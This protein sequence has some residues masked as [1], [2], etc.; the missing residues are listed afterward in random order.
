[1]GAPYEEDGAAGAGAPY[2]DEGAAGAGAPYEEDPPPPP[3]FLP[4]KKKGE[5]LA[6]AINIARGMVTKV[7]HFIC[8]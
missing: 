6:S 2:E 1:M 4:S 5:A 7:A 3:P 8:K